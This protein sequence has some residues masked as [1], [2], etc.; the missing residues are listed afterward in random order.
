MNAKVSSTF[1]AD[2]LDVVVEF[3]SAM[4]GNLICALLVLRDPTALF[5]SLVVQLVWYI[6]D[7]DE[8]VKLPHFYHHKYINSN[9]N[10]YI[11]TKDESNADTVKK[12]MKMTAK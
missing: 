11:K 1:I 4:T 10:V 7:H 2:P 9:Y 6:L 12:I 8:N 3:G 5:W